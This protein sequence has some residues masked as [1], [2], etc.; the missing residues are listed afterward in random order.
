MARRPGRPA[1]TRPGPARRAQERAET[2]LRAV[3]ERVLP[4]PAQ[5]RSARRRRSARAQQ[6]RP[7][8]PSR[9]KVLLASPTTWANAGPRRA[10]RGR[11]LE[12]AR[13]VRRRQLGLLGRPEPGGHDREAAVGH[14]VRDQLGPGLLLGL[15]QRAGGTRGGGAEVALGGGVA[16]ALGLDPVGVEATEQRR[17]AARRSSAAGGRAARRGPCARRPASGAARR[18]RR[19]PRATPLVNAT[20]SPPPSRPVRQAAA[21][22]SWTGTASV[23]RHAAGQQQPQGHVDDA[24]DQAGVPLVGRCCSTRA[25]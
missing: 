10:S 18:R 12:V 24:G 8:P 23:G 4:R 13:E 1:S 9:R 3:I 17:A 7:G 19:E 15:R 20:G 22:R 6:R 14:L 5:H 25:R 11:G 21:S 2:A 16:A